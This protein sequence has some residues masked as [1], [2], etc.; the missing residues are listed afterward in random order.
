MLVMSMRAAARLRRDRSGVALIEFAF[1]LPMLLAMGCGAME[2][3]SLSLANMR[4]S[5]ATIDLAD[6]VARMGRQST[7]TSYQVLSESDVNDAIQ[8]LRLEAPDLT[9]NGRVTIS[10][11]E[12]RTD[13]N[14]NPVQFL[15]WQRC[16][17]LQPA[18]GASPSS[19]ESS[20][21]VPA[22]ATKPTNAQ[23]PYDDSGMAVSGMSSPLLTAPPGS[24]LMFV[25]INYNYTSIFSQLPI[26]DRLL[27]G[28]RRLH[29]VSTMIVRQ[30]RASTD[31]I[32]NTAQ[33]TRM[34][35]NNHT[36]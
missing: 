24:G 29:Y 13:S 12:A 34:T 25:E 26:L 7:S 33:V 16:V 10:S 14:G 18:A 5:H 35:C 6:N 17:G 4:I 36:T 22:G 23:A 30:A 20:A 21:V 19:Y 8:A 9:T 3:A 1:T 32:D 2:L 11:L 28:S 27:G 31:P 15:H